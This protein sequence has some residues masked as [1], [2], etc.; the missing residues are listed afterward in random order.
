MSY[1]WLGANEYAGA[2]SFSDWEPI[3][4]GRRPTFK[5]QEPR[6]GLVTRGRQQP[7]IWER[8]FFF[9]IL[10]RRRLRLHFP[11]TPGGKRRRRRNEDQLR[12]RGELGKK[13]PPPAGA[14][15]I[16]T[17]THKTISVQTA[18][19]DAGRATER[20]GRAGPAGQR[21]QQPRG[22]LSEAPIK[23][24]AKNISEDLWRPEK[25]R[26]ESEQ[27]EGGGERRRSGRV[28]R[29]GRPRWRRGRRRSRQTFL[30]SAWFYIAL[31]SEES[32]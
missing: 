30:F 13:L 8:A 14:A 4:C 27:E 7:N 18:S 5:R 2:D 24:P 17:H 9:Q 26:R 29:R 20:P 25:K 23:Y 1:L 10:Q 28:G 12:A 21:Q 6:S 32:A 15:A 11:A 31:A 19:A 16:S 22:H 3:I